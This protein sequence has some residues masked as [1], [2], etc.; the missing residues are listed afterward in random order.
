MPFHEKSI[1]L[2]AQTEPI[3]CSQISLKGEELLISSVQMVTVQ[4]HYVQ[5]E[6]LGM[7]ACVQFVSSTC[8]WLISA[9]GGGSKHCS[10]YCLSVGILRDFV[11]KNACNWYCGLQKLIEEHFEVS[12][13]KEENKKGLIGQ[14]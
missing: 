9:H 6:N 2:V 5:E 7:E 3:S 11:N 12:V 10:K 1:F 8:A 13:K 14:K 4:L